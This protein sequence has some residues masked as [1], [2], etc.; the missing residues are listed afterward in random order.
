VGGQLHAP[1]A[2]P[3]GKGHPIHIGYEAGW[4]LEPVL[5]L[6]RKEKYLAPAG[7]RSPALQPIACLCTHSE[8]I[9][10]HIAVK[11]FRQDAGWETMKNNFD[12][13]YSTG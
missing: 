9:V 2:L 10:F 6:W 3:P 8:K 5:T 7:N 4:A 13:Q 1:I 11:L 12:L